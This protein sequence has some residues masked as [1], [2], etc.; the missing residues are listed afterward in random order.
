MKYI[1]EIVNWMYV[2]CTDF[3]INVTNFTKLS[4]FEINAFLFCVLWPAI[5]IILIL[6]YIKQKIRLNKKL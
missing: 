5:T 6:I 2:Y 1:L 3:V 4:Y